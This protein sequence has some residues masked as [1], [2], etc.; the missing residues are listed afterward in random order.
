MKIVGAAGYDLAL[1][2]RIVA[3]VE[4][5]TSVKDAARLFSVNVMTVYGYLKR[6]RQGQLHVVGKPTGR[7]FRL[8]TV[9][10]AHLLEQL[11][12][13]G[14]ATL[15]E[16]ATGLKVSLWTVDRAFRRLKITHKKTLVARERREER[17]A[18]FLNDLAPYLQTPSQMVFLDESGFNTA[19]TRG[20]ARAPSHLRAVGQVARNHGLNQTLICGLRLAGPLAPLVIPGAVN[21]ETFEWYVREQLCPALEPGQVLVMDNLSSHHRASVRTLI[22]A[23]GCTLLYLSPYSPDFNPIE[24]MFSKLKALVRGGGWSNLDTLM[25]AIGRALQSVTLSDTC[26]W[27]RHAHPSMFLC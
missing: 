19:M 7:P 23:R 26:G 14:D 2:G 5:G 6:H 8:T 12:T 15:L 21:G 10:E 24:M 25:D 17:R 4:G 16:A 13:H 3:A 9:H 27:F 18:A 11:K 22:E 1:R 20:Y